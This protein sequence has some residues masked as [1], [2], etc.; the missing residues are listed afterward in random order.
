MAKT[1]ELNVSPRTDLG[2]AASRR[3]RRLE[4]HIPAVIYGIG[5]EPESVTV[6]HNDVI[7]SLKDEGFYSQVI[8]LH[9]GSKKEQV[10]LK[11]MQ[12]HPSKPS[13]LHM[14]FLRIDLNAKLTTHTPLHYVG[15]DMAPGV[16]NQGGVVSHHLT[17]VELRCLPTDLPKFI[18]IDLSALEMN[19]SIHLSDIKLPKGI[20]LVALTLEEPNDMM[21]ANVHAPVAAATDEEPVGEEKSVEEPA[22]DSDKE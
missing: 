18:E 21:V 4:N 11:D 17:E 13:V 9:N 6:S 16:K 5:K 7:K 10:I 12:R 2:K 15:G 14:D 8:T 1:Y 22:S 20:E 3:M 19:D